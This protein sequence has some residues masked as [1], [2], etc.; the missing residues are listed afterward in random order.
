[1]PWKDN[2]T[3]SNEVAVS[4]YNVRWP[5]DRQMAMLVT[6]NLNPAAKP[7]G[8]T[9]KDLAYPTWHFGM[10]EGLDAFLDLFSDLGI[11]A[12]FAVPAVIA[13]SYAA[14]METILDHGHEIAA[15]GLF[16]ED[17]ATLSPEQEAEHIQ[18]ATDIITRITG[19]RPEGWYALSRPDD[20]FATGSVTDRTIGLLKAAGYRYFGNGLADDAPYWWVS[21]FDK[22]EGLLTLPYYYHFDDTYFLMFPREGTGLERP[23][24]LKR[25]WHAEFRAQYRRERCFNMCVSPALSGWSHRFENMA[26]F[27]TDAMSHPGVWAATGAEVAAHWRKHYPEGPELGLEAPIWQDYADSLS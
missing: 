3:T 16:G 7:S 17:P 15:Q 22:A 9:E 5:G 14:R 4:D 21:D 2:Y 13:D 27:L 10:N 12:T 6:V 23:E 19:R 18:S 24:A 20:L 26:E 25:N 8:I 1:M 11:K